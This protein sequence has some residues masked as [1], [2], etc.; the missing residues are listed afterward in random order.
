MSLKYLKVKIKSRYNFLIIVECKLSSSSLQAIFP[1]CDFKSN[2][3]SNFFLQRSFLATTTFVYG[4]AAFW[5]KLARVNFSKLRV[6]NLVELPELLFVARVAR[7][8]HSFTF[9]C[10]GFRFKD[11]NR[12]SVLNSIAYWFS[13]INPFQ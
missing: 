3:W 1:Y 6:C 8:I 4:F 5:L 13:L 9:H 12:A 7:I 11:S 2:I 10:Q